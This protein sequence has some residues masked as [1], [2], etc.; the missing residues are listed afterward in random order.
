MIVG[1]GAARVRDLFKQA[2]EHAPA[3]IFIDELDAIGRARGSDGDRRLERAGADAQPDPDGDGR[4]LEPRGDHRAR[5]DQSAGRAGQGAASPRSFR[6]A[7][8][9]QPARPKGTR[10]DPER[11]HAQCAAGD[12]REPGELAAATP[13]FSGADLRNLVNEAAL[14]AARRDQ[15]E[16][17]APKDFLDALEKI[18]LGPERPLLLSPG[19]SR[20]YRLS[21]RR[22]RDPRPRRSGRRSGAP[23]DDRAARTGARRHLST[24]GRRSIQLSRGV[25]AR[26]HRRDARRPRCGGDRLRHTNDRRGERHRAS[27]GAGA[28][29]GHALGHE[30][31]C[32]AWCSSRRARIRTSAARRVTTGPK[33]FSEE[34]AE[35]IDEEVRRIIG[36]SHDEAKRLLTQ[37]RKQL[38]ALVEALLARETLD[39]QE[40]LE[41]TRLPPAPKIDGGRLPIANDRVP[42]S[43]PSR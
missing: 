37:H 15:D 21:R 4:L 31:S 9:G 32:S 36:E 18:V 35:A 2:R 34:T 1:V 14:L 13:G 16:R 25:S 17:S 11:A 20:T 27:H 7:R 40:I 24:P 30:R 41:A 5:G 33:P 42:N 8:G 22:T 10:G 19:R 3:I 38:D 39:E 23:R 26:P 28:Q 43:E 6:S 12:G 29:H